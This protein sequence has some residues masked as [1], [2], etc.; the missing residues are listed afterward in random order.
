LGS[1]L[2]FGIAVKLAD[3][4]VA[5]LSGAFGEIVDEIFDEIPAGFP[6]CGG[7]AVIGCIGLHEARIEVVLANEQAEAVAKA[8]LTIAIVVAVVSVR[9][10][11]GPLG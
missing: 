11:F 5:I 6:E 2:R 10:R 4:A 9:G 3:Q 1:L 8:R 7:A